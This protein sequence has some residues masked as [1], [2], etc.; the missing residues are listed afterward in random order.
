MQ[1]FEKNPVRLNKQYSVFFHDKLKFS[2]FL[3]YFVQCKKLKISYPSKPVNIWFCFKISEI[4]RLARKVRFWGLVF[5]RRIIGI[6]HNLHT[7]LNGS[8]NAKG[9]KEDLVMIWAYR[10]IV[11][12]SSKLAIS[13]PMT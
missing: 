2:I 9:T 13:G 8:Q 4:I 1:N 5:M 10:N 11:I 12:N 7:K 6:M 3:I